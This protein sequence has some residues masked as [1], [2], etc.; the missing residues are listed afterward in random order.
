M[1]PCAHLTLRS[2]NSKTGPIPVSTTS[3]ESCPPSCPLRKK[4]CYGKAG[5]LGIHWRLVSTSKR[6]SSWEEFCTA[7]AALP[8]GTLF[9]HNQAGDLPGHDGIIDHK[10]LDLLVQANTGK[11]GFTYTHYQPTQRNLS[12]IENAVSRGLCINLSANNLAHADELSALEVAPVVTLVPLGSPPRLHTPE[13]RKVVLCPAQSRDDVTCMTCR[14]CAR[15]DRKVIIGFL[16]HG[17]GAK[18]ANEIANTTTAD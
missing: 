2:S 7:V 11:R 18:A 17:S 15:A 3:A 16:P 14:M 8:E 4:A 12:A 6:G 1:S 10:K 9:R 13:G 5:P